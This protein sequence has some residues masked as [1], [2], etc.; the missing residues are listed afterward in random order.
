ME[1]PPGSSGWMCLS[2]SS[3]SIVH[4][5][6]KKKTLLFHLTNTVCRPTMH[7]HT[8]TMPLSSV[9]L[10]LPPAFSLRYQEVPVVSLCSKTHPAGGRRSCISEVHSSDFI[11]SLSFSQVPAGAG[12]AG[13]QQGGPGGGEGG[14]PQ[15]GPGAR[16]GL[17]LPLHGDVG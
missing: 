15:R 2:P 14:V 17:G 11:L 16:R 5:S 10:W 7:T 4:C 6:K 13:G 9:S 3:H 1:A 12:G 8:H